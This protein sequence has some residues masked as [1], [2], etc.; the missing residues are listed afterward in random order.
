M[1]ERY[2]ESARRVLFFARY[3]A[4]QFGSLA[5][6]ADHLLLGLIREGK[7]VTHRLLSSYVALPDLRKEIEGRS[8]IRE[9]IAT[10]IEIPFTGETKRILIR[11]AEEADRLRHQYIGTEHLLLALLREDQSAPAR[12]LAAHG[13]RLDEART[14]LVRLLNEPAAADDHLT[15]EQ[16]EFDHDVRMYVFR[17]AAA[18]AHVPQA[19][20]IASAISRS[21]AEVR[22]ALKRLAA[23]KVLILA[24]NDGN[25]WAANPFCAVPSG[26]RVVSRGTTYWGIC[27]WDALGVVAALGADA[28]ITAPCGDCGE[29]MTLEIR[30]GA[31]VRSEGIVHFAVPARDWWVNIGFS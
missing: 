3:E 29:P 27:I 1:F 28:V 20:Q 18:T 6:E 19:P 26:F 31:L 13:L 5:I 17:E 11:A 22:E 7:G 21:E 9:K 12:T 10:S 24:P 4:S 25:I 8:V 2:T 23:A 14:T 16:K 15:L 30:D